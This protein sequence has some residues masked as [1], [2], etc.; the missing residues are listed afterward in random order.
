MDSLD[1][2]LETQPGRDNTHVLTEGTLLGSWRIGGLLGRGGSA[3]VYHAENVQTGESAAVKI[4]VPSP[5]LETRRLRFE[6]EIQ[7]LSNLKSSLF[8][9]LL[10]QGVWNG[11]P[12]LVEEQ[13]EHRELPDGDR[14]CARFLLKICRGISYLHAA[15]FVHRD[16]KPGNILFRSTGEPVIIDL[17]LIKRVDGETDISIVDGRPVAVGTPGYAAP[18]Q[19]LSGGASFSVDIHA[20]GVLANAC[21]HDRP[22][23]VWRRIICRATSSLQERRYTTV[24]ALAWAIRLRHLPMVGWALLGIALVAAS[25]MVLSKPHAGAMR[26]QHSANVVPRTTF[27]ELQELNGRTVKYAEPIVLESNRT[28]RIVGPGRID[29]DVSGPT[30]AVLILK[31]C[32]FI[33]RTTMP[34]PQNGVRYRLDDGV[35]LNFINLHGDARAVGRGIEPYDGAYNQVRCNGPESLEELKQI[36]LKNSVDRIRLDAPVL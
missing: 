4:L 3:E 32:V 36:E 2:Y 25:M 15:G 9:R 27:P 6:R 12:Y 19:F 31:K 21:F 28:Y 34:Y 22:S 8:P 18:E 20:L 7:I 26:Q 30:N 23:W 24:G 16:I 10:D 14:V 29:V 11:L 5:R 17:G 1:R 33:N 35:Y 13:L